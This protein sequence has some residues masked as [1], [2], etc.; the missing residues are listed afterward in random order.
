MEVVI[1]D[2]ANSELTVLTAGPYHE[3]LA[4][5]SAN[6]NRI[7]FNRRLPDWPADYALGIYRRVL[8]LVDVPTE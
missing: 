6:G 4:Y 2:P 8:C 5:G 1:F 7:V 3:E